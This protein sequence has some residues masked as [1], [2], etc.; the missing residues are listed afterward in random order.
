L[1][2]LLGAAILRAVQER[3][4]PQRQSGLITDQAIFN[5]ARIRNMLD[6][7]KHGTL[8]RLSAGEE[9]GTL[10]GVLS[11]ERVL[12]IRSGDRLVIHRASGAG[13]W[14]QP[15]NLSPCNYG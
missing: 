12:E 7:R 14:G 1:V 11:V 13:I 9:K 3:Q 5:S 4:T 6:A 2:V 8:V 10:G 15:L